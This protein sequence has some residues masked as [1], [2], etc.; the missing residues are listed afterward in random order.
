MY[1]V[2]LTG[3]KQHKVEV[4]RYF[5][6]EKIAGEVGSKVN[7][8]CLLFVDD[9]GN[10]SAGKA[11]SGVKVVAEILEHGKADKILVTK[12]KRKKN[13]HKSQGHRQPYTKLMIVSI[14]K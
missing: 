12:Y 13:Y 7:L 3:G 4:G 10:V 14:G 2:V 11:A 6:A 8:D 1:A 9:K 5:L